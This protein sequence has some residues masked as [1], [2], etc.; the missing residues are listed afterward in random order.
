M[1]TSLLEGRVRR[2]TTYAVFD[3]SLAVGLTGVLHGVPPKFK[4]DLYYGGDVSVILF[5]TQNP[6]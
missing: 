4:S 1:A 5:M 6:T 2:L 3:Y